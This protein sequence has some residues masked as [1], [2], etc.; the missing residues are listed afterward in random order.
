MIITMLM[1]RIMLASCV[2]PLNLYAKMPLQL[3]YQAAPDPFA[4]PTLQKMEEKTV[5][6]PPAKGAVEVGTVCDNDYCT[7]K[8]SAS[9]LRDTQ[10]LH[11]T[12][13]KRQSDDFSTNQDGNGKL[14]I[15]G[16]W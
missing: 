15:S 10:R 8:E 6:F 16:E 13:R 7:R 12:D 2:L 4:K 3:E 14:Y 9:G 5:Q 1:R 11:R